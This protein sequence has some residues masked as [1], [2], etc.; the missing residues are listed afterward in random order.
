MRNPRVNETVLPAA[1]PMQPEME[2]QRPPQKFATNV[3]VL[4]HSSFCMHPFIK[5]MGISPK[6]PDNQLYRILMLRNPA[7]QTGYNDNKFMI[8]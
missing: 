6:P 7:G 3:C 1:E 5:S 8:K 2:S 4:H